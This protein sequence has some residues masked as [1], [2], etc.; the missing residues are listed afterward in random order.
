MARALVSWIGGLK[1]NQIA[2]KTSA[3]SAV[4]DILVENT[5]R[6]NFGKQLRGEWKGITDSVTLA[7]RALTGWQIYSLP[8]S[9][10]STLHFSDAPARGP[11]FY[12]GSFSLNEIGDTFLDTRGWHKGVA[13]I[14]GHCLGRVWD[15]G[16]Q[17]TLYVPA[18]WLKR[19][20]N[21]VIVF[22]LAEQPK[23]ILHALKEPILDSIRAAK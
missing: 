8:M 23:P 21:E 22:D 18:P 16:P 4:L 12:R 15:I 5:G 14:N 1:Q 20:A 19:G 13:W 11:A 10:L 2:L 9:D 17:Q 7:D 3:Q 6:I